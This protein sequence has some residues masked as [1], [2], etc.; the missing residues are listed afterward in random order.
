[1]CGLVALITKSGQ[2]W[3]RIHSL[4]FGALLALL[5]FGVVTLF[6]ILQ[7]NRT[8]D[9]FKNDLDRVRQIFANH[10]DP[11]YVLADYQPLRATPKR[12]E[13]ELP[14]YL[15]KSAEVRRAWLIWSR[16]L[17]ACSV[18]AFAGAWAYDHSAHPLRIGSAALLLSGLAHSVL[19]T[20]HDW[21]GKRKL[22]QD[23]INTRWRSRLSGKMGTSVEYLIV[24]PSDNQF[25]WVLPKGHIKANGNI[26][27]CGRSRGVGRDGLHCEGADKV[28]NSFVFFQR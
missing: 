19:I 2:P 13:S 15:G 4:V 9:G 28:R 18:G 21:L 27:T 5:A 25:E 20:V 3:E 22:D 24:R 6:R 12:G 17:T 8:D 23:G 7:R 1:L 10:F 14:N 11:E 16:L 26:R